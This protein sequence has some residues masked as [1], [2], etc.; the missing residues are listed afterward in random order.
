MASE[1]LIGALAPWFGAKRTLASRIIAEFG[2]HSC[3]W[4]P[5]CGSCAVMLAK[6]PVSTE[7]VNDLHGDVTSLAMTLADPDDALE[8]YR[9]LA[10][11]I[12]CEA[13]WLAGRKYLSGI[14]QGRTL[15]DVMRAKHFLVASWLARNGYGGCDEWAS[16]FAVRFSTTGGG[17]AGRWRAVVQSI[18]AWHQRLCNV[19]I[20]NR[21]CFELIERI[22]DD[23]GT[24]IYVDPPYVH[25]GHRYDHKFAPTDHKRL[26]D[27]LARFRR[28][29]VVVSYYDHDC[30]DYLY[31][32]W[33]KVQLPT[34]KFLEKSGQ[35]DASGT[36]TTAPEVLLINGPCLATTATLFPENP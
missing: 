33:T 8:L 25:E 6:A 32:G 22:G 30:L 18:P 31:A 35:R 14:E 29:R 36:V 19:T 24:V 16:S 23:A 20:L 2:E 9:E 13:T 12:P 1:M 7:T 28:A 34:P 4:E 3:Y 5:M 15:P 10:G 27:A 17:G 21:D 26:A 11:V